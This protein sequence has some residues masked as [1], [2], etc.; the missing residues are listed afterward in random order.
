MCSMYSA[1]ESSE[2]VQLIGQYCSRYLAALCHLSVA[3][4]PA[5]QGGDH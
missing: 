1:V 5:E 3:L 2:C 4:I